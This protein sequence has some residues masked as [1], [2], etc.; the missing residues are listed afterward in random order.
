MA[1]ER[2]VTVNV[3]DPATREL[4]GIG[5]AIAGHCQPCFTYHYQEALKLGVRADAIQAAIELA[6]AV[7]G[8]GDRYMDEFVGRR[9]AAGSAP[10]A[11]ADPPGQPA[12]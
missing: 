7:R 9:L 2:Q 6:R 5:A 10:H 1:P 3:L 11:A 4:V 12:P 8:S